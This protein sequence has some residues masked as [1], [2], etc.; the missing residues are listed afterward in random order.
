MLRKIRTFMIRAF[1]NRSLNRRFNI[2]DES[3]ETFKHAVIT[4]HKTKFSGFLS[5]NVI[6]GSPIADNV[7]SLFGPMEDGEVI[8]WAPADCRWPQLLKLLGVFP[9]AGQARKNGWDKDIEEGWSEALFKKQRK[10]VFI[11]KVTR[12]V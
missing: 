9:S 11:L 10:A 1:R 8:V 3:K 5:A 12:D 7:E 2:S 6:I 4:A